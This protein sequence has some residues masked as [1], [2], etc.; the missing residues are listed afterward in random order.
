LARGG[1]VLPLAIMRGG[2]LMFSP[3]RDTVLNTGNTLILVTPVQS[4]SVTR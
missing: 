2:R 1:D 3:L 4:L